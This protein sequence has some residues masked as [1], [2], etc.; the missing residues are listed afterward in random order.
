MKK[1]IIKK[2]NWRIRKES[3]WIYE[4]MRHFE[5]PSG[6][7]VQYYVFRR[8]NISCFGTVTDIICL[9]GFNHASDKSDI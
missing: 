2:Q 5:N 7:N 4:S 3:E 1:K 8:P 6:K 9:R